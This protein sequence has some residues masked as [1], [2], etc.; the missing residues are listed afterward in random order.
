MPNYENLCKPLKLR[1]L[2]LK[3]RMLSAPTS[4]AELGAGERYS[5]EN[6]AYYK[7]KAMGGCA[8]VTVGDVIVDNTTGRSHPQQVGFNDPGALPY[9]TQMA[10]AIHQGGAAASVEIDHGGALCSPAFLDGKNAF[11]PSG[12][13][14]DWGDVVEEMTEEQIYAVAESYGRAAAA[15]KEC[16]F[17]MVMIHGGHGWLVHQFISEI[18]NHRTD[19]WGGSFENRMRFPLLVVQKVREAV[20]NNFP[21]EIRISGSER[22][23]GGYGIETGVEIAKALDG[24]VDL[25]HVSA[26]TQEDFYSF[27]LMHPGIFQKHGENSGLAAEIKKH[28][29]TPVVSVGAFSEPDLMEQFLAEGGADAIAMGRA[30]IADPFLPQKVL[31]NQTSEIRPCLRCGQC[32]GGMMKNHVLRCTINPLIGRE[33]E[34][35]HPLPIRRTGKVMIVGGGP[36]GMQAALEAAEAGNQVV[37]YEARARLG[38]ALKF[39]DETDFK[40]TMKKYRDFMIAQVNKN[41]AITI[42]LNTKATKETVEAE[43][44]D[45]LIIAVGASPIAPPVPGAKNDN[46]VFGADITSETPIGQNVVVI[47]GGMIGCEEAVSMARAGKNV[48]LVEMRDELAIDCVATYRISLLHEVECAE[49][50]TPMTS[51]ALKE[52]SAEG[53]RV[54]QKIFAECEDPEAAPQLLRV[55]EKVIPADTVIMAVGMRSNDDIVDGLRGLVPF[56]Y[57]IGDC[58]RAGRVEHATQGAHNAVVNFGF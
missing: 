25:I 30:L 46:V 17:D 11:G 28:V 3:N 37:L 7:Y 33:L 45:A 29:K 13:V 55:E 26:G 47:G 44:P 51:T 22:M 23:P 8:L 32:Q 38:G 58:N 10:D 56:T 12:Y 57:V 18:T 27:I 43:A 15:A 39:A 5:A 19:E 34:A 4:L 54:E 1:G 52:I 31:T 49:T 42:H 53:V 2:T 41:E 6:Y 14:D 36:G 50:I 16:G 35:M 20:G 40:A 48:T 21:I 24:K 9:L